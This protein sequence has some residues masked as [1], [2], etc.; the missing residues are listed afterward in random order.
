MRT[1]TRGALAA[2]LLLLVTGCT[3]TTAPAAGPATPATPPPPVPAF[4]AQ[5]RPKLTEA[6]A[7]LKL[8]GAIVEVTVPG[9]GTWL[10]AL[11]SGSTDGRT[12]I[13]IDDHIRIG[14]VTKSVTAEVV[15]QLADSRQTAARRPGGE[16]PA[17]DPGR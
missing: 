5:L 6:M 3:T 15:L 11:G 9:Q 8:P 4:A 12:P 16:I 7:R 13:T 14:S 1:R 17:A 10:E 2:A